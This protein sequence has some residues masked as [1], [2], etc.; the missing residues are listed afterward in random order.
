[1]D[2]WEDEEDIGNVGSEY[3]G[4]DG[5]CEDNED[6]TGDRNGDQ[7]LVRLNKG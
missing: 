4:E 7:R 2:G 5:N 6:E 3:E 1:M